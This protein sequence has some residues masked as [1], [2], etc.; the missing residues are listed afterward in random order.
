[1]R[2]PFQIPLRTKWILEEAIGELVEL[3][4]HE[5]QEDCGSEVFDVRFAGYRDY[6]GVANGGARQLLRADGP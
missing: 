3:N 5:N 4:E 6:D 2:S 1:M